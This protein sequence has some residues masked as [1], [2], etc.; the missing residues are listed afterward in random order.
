MADVDEFCSTSFVDVEVPAQ[1]VLGE[2]RRRM[3]GRA[4]HPVVRTRPDLLAARRLARPTISELLLGRPADATVRRRRWV[5]PFSCCGRSGPQSKATQDRI[6]AGELP[7]PE[8]SVD[9]IM[10][11]AADQAVFDTARELFAVHRDR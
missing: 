4:A 3:A 7:G 1:R 11:A 6:A 8:A 5:R 10:I 9:K 2:H